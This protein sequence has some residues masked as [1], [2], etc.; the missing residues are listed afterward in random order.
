MPFAVRFLTGALLAALLALPARPARA[1]LGVEA[2]LG[3]GYEVSPTTESQATN[4]MIAPGYDVG[5][6]L[7]AELGLV[8]L[9]GAARAGD[10]SG[11]NLEFRPMLVLSPPI[12]P[13]YGRLVVAAVNPF[14]ADRTLA[15]GG[16]AGIS[17]GLGGVGVFGELGL[18]PRSV[19]NAIHWVME[20]RA[21]VS[22]GF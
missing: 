6:L 1:G 14:S 3:Y 19:A 20:G 16:A 10:T 13:I 15:Y 9:Y 17:L 5:G 2:S 12:L 7:R 18:L 22:L 21:G 8:G 4:I 11:L